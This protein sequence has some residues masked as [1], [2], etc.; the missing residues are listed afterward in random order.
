[1]IFRH[2]IKSLEKE[3]EQYA[4][5]LQA[6]FFQPLQ[7]AFYLKNEY[8]SCSHKPIKKQKLSP[9]RESLLN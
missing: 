4:A 9:F 1:L 2:A 5:D 6:M 3:N 8:V 7:F